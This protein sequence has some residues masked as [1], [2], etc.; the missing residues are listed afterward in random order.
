MVAQTRT[1]S[2]VQTCHTLLMRTASARPINNLLLRREAKFLLKFHLWTRQ[3][4]ALC[5]FLAS[6]TQLHVH[7]V[8]AFGMMLLGPLPSAP[9][10]RPGG[11][12]W[13]T[14]QPHSQVTRLLFSL[15]LCTAHAHNTTQGCKYLNEAVVES[16][17]SLK[18]TSQT[19]K[20]LFYSFFSLFS[21]FPS[22]SGTPKRRPREDIY[23]PVTCMTAQSSKTHFACGTSVW[24]CSLLRSLSISPLALLP[25]KVHLCLHTPL[26]LLIGYATTRPT[27]LALLQCFLKSLLPP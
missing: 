18:Q 26:L 6:L 24:T 8:H 1:G 14:S 13:R 20:V 19:Q 22:S 25:S 17:F 2:D 21:F 9:P 12:S 16:F 23:I 27:E 15:V 7:A 10:H 5:S 3:V 4:S 11:T